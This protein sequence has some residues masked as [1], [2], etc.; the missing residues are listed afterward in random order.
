MSNAELYPLQITSQSPDSLG[1]LTVEVIPEDGD[2]LNEFVLSTQ[3]RTHKIAVPVGR[4]AV[5]ARRPNG[6]RL[7]RS[8]EVKGDPSAKVDLAAGLPA[9]ANK[10][11]QPEASRGEI[12]IQRGSQ[13]SSRG[14]LDVL[15]GFA[16]QTQAAFSSRGEGSV[17]S[18]PTSEQKRWTVKAWNWPNQSLS[19][20]G[21]AHFNFEKG[22]SVL[23]VVAEP[24]C[25]ALGLLDEA[26]FGPIVMT[27]P[28]RRRLHVT[29]LA[30]CLHLRAAA[31]YLNPSGQRSL[32]ALVT[33]EEPEVA[34]LL[35]ALSSVE[36]EHAGSLWDQ[37]QASPTNAQD[38]VYEKFQHPA[39]ALLG[40]HFLLRFL[41]DRLPL[42]WADNLRH[43]FPEAADGPVIAAWLRMTSRSPEISSHNP[44][45][46]HREVER[47][48]GNAIEQPIC[49]FA[50]TRRLLNDGLRLE[51]IDCRTFPLSDPA[52]Y[53]D[54][55]AHAGGLEAF[56]GTHPFSP[57]PT[58]RSD[59]LASIELAAVELDGANFTRLF[60]TSSGGGQVNGMRS[61]RFMKA[62][63]AKKRPKKSVSK[64]KIAKKKIAKKK[65]TKKAK[66]AKQKKSQASKSV[67]KSSRARR[68]TARR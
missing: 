45:D 58:S 52:P 68:K 32:V 54:Y 18:T 49:W 10:F 2:S 39:E 21:A 29:F 22:R 16:G 64:K 6:D 7:Y 33:P 42:G 63:A 59:A 66:S 47:L 51:N 5:I 30:E 40:A 55:G 31:R 20:I 17:L 4:Y 23:K 57:G 27:P 19:Q 15:K 28:F 41:P 62:A 46:L 48:L 61:T 1:P 38:F 11:M 24:H 12:A 14:Q 8:V 37:N 26:G 44:K 43:A 56:W 9:S 50:R 67:G 13:R 34:D 36:L 65:A 35:S 53:L 25:L 3:Y 60:P